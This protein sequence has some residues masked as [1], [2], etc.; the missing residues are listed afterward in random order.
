MDAFPF[1]NKISK[2]EL[3]NKTLQYLKINKH[4]LEINPAKVVQEL[5]CNKL[6]IYISH[7][8]S[9]YYEDICIPQI[10]LEVW[11]SV[12]E[13]VTSY[14]VEIDMNHVEAKFSYERSSRKE[15]IY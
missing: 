4:Y 14:F 2:I 5:Y 9:Q 13:I 12:N 1:I 6:N 11:F 8:K 7:W 10:D 3:K 15:R